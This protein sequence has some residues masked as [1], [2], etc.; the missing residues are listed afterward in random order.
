MFPELVV[1]MN[2]RV[3]SDHFRDEASIFPFIMSG[4]VPIYRNLD[5]KQLARV[6]GTQNMY[7][8]VYT[9]QTVRPAFNGHSIEG[10][11]NCENALDL[12]IK[13]NAQDLR[14]ST[15][16]L[17]D[18]RVVEIGSILTEVKSE[19]NQNSRPDIG[20]SE[21]KKAKYEEEF[22]DDFSTDDEKSESEDEFRLSSSE[23]EAEIADL[24]LMLM[25]TKNR[26]QSEDTQR[27][28]KPKLIR[29]SK[30]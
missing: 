8:G 1:T 14:P 22:Q 9:D 5:E 7:V 26:F 2:F 29:T 21:P 25:T 17:S 30:H 16:N 12:S 27:E 13:P 6:L 20:V 28:T 24:Q 4:A 10:D 18:H 19:R 23:D 11:Q 3:C 15:S